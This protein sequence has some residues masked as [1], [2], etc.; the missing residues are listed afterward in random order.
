MTDS[1]LSE[2]TIL[3]DMTTTLVSEALGPDAC[4]EIAER[5]ARRRVP[6]TAPAQRAGIRAT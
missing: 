3:V 5:F 2:P 4:A 6:E 1:E